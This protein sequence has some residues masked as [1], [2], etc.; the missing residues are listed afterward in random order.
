[1]SLSAGAPGI[2][3]LVP[4][5]RGGGGPLG[6]LKLG[7]AGQ[8]HNGCRRAWRSAAEWP[9]LSPLRPP[10]LPSQEYLKTG[11]EDQ[12]ACAASGFPPSLPAPPPTSAHRLRPWAASPS[13]REGTGLGTT[14]GGPG[15]TKVLEAPRPAAGHQPHFRRLRALPRDGPVSNRARAVH[16]LSPRVPRARFQPSNL[17]PP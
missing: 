3:Q 6:A 5:W 9:P 8:T 16:Q 2:F 17:R 12:E 10:D 11:T 15:R 14:S 7:T 1:M 13:G 4:A